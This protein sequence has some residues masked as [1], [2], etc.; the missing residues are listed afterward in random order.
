M[1]PEERRDMKRIAFFT[2][3]V[4]MT[5]FGFTSC[6]E[7]EPVVAEDDTP[8][9][10]VP[11]EDEIAFDEYI[12]GIEANDSLAAGNSLYYSKGNGQST[13]VEFFV[14][15]KNE[16]VK[17]VEY[18]TQESMTIAKNVFYFKDNRK[19]ASM[20]LFETGEGEEM[21]FVERV[22]Y[23]GENEEPIIT[24]QKTAIY[25]QDLD[26]ESYELVDKHDCDMKHA[27]EILNQEG[28]FNT[29]FQGFVK[30]GAFLYLI[31]GGNDPEAFSSS[32]VVQYVDQTIKKLQENETAMIGVPL[33]INF[34]TVE[35]AGE[36]FEYQILLSAVVR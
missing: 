11:N 3:A 28:E 4:S 2:V 31:V 30:E 29:T 27:L 10:Y 15:D 33:T 26:V 13:E 19:F 8:E 21:H 7:A 32:L 22:S 1:I 5:M 36:G 9:V 16:M 18:Y 12:A 14:N 6:G 17:M 34:E 20:E 35:D 23:Y 24:K 25:E